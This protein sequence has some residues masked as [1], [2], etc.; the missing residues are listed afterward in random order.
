MERFVIDAVGGDAEAE[1]KGLLW[2]VETASSADE[3]A[4]VVVPDVRSIEGLSRALSATVGDTAKKD[5]Q[6]RIDGRR[7]AVLNLNAL[8]GSFAGS[9]LVLWA[10]TEMAEKAESLRPSAI[11]ASSWS[12]GDLDEWK[13]TWSPVNLTGEVTPVGNS[14]LGLE[15]AIVWT[16]TS[17]AGGSDVLHPSD[18]R[19][20]VEEFKA[21]QVL[22]IPFDPAR[23][24]AIARRR[25]WEPGGADRLEGIAKKITEGRTVKGAGSMTKAKAKEILDR[26]EGLLEDQVDSDW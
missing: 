24:R 21:L 13:R 16:L 18:K 9:V 5:R 19:R 22:G 14:A 1:A 2:L 6:F 10:N 12:E 26:L 15:D 25:G 7:V 8:P 23:A 11:C 17:P 20:V 4:A 3:E